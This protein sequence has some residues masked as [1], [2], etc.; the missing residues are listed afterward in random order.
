MEYILARELIYPFSRGLRSTANNFKLSFSARR[1]WMLWNLL[2]FYRLYL[3]C[4]ISLNLVWSECMRDANSAVLSGRYTSTSD[5]A[6]TLDECCTKA[7]KLDPADQI[8]DDHRL[9]SP[10][11][12]C[13]RVTRLAGRKVAGWRISYVIHSC[14]YCVRYRHYNLTISETTVKTWPESLHIL[15]AS[16]NVPLVVGLNLPHKSW[17]FLPNMFWYMR[18]VVMD[19]HRAGRIRATDGFW[20]L[21]AKPDVANRQ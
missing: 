5:Y 14:C 3:F 16:A 7:N 11:S 17:E 12:F 21:L 6:G 8:F 10:L 4:M 18:V 1:A 2:E 19:K 13:P 15:C 9:R 20:L